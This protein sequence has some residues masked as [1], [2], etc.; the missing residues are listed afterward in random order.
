MRRARQR[1]ARVGAHA[2]PVVDV[3]GSPIPATPTTTTTTTWLSSVRDG[4]QLGE[5]TLWSQ[6]L[7]NH[8]VI[9]VIVDFSGTDN[10]DM[11]VANFDQCFRRFFSGQIRLREMRA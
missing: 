3:F 5:S 11:P 2:K 8:V 7:S 9:T 1:P 4:V 6:F 10:S